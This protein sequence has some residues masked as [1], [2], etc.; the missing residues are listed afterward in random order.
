VHPMPWCSSQNSLRYVGQ[1]TLDKAA[2][3]AACDLSLTTLVN[4]VAEEYVSSE[5]LEQLM[6]CNPLFQATAACSLEHW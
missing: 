5:I 6:Y 4:T 2:A 1:A 3:I